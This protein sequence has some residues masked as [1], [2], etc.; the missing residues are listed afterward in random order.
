MQSES[1]KQNFNKLNSVFRQTRVYGKYYTFLNLAFSPTTADKT[2]A[3]F[4]V[5][6]IS[7]NLCFGSRIKV[8]FHG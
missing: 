6:V 1:I 3:T 7:V 5:P 4:H 8:S 2:F